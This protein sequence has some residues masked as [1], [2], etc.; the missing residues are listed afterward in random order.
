MVSLIRVS[1]TPGL[2]TPLLKSQKPQLSLNSNFER[3]GNSPPQK[4][5]YR[6]AL[7][8]KEHWKRNEY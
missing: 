7:F 2:K 1:S 5:A 6:K 4:N 8:L 3:V